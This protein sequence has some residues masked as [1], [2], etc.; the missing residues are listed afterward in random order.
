MRRIIALLFFCVTLTAIA[1]AP[2]Q[3]RIRISSWYWLNAAPQSDWA[4]DFVT[5][6]HLGFTDVLL[7]WGLDAAGVVTRKNDTLEAIR[8]AHRAGLGSYLFIWQPRAQSLPLNPKFQQVDSDGRLLETFDTFNPEW[9]HTQWKTYLQDI[10][11][12]YSREPGLAGYVFDD[13]FTSP[14]GNGFVS[15]GEFERKAFG[16]TLPKKP[17]EPDWDEW[18]QKRMGWWEDWAR[19][20]VG[21]LHDF[22]RHRDHEIYLE[23]TATSLLSGTRREHAGLDFMR[24]ARHFDAVGGYT[25]PRWSSDLDADKKVA[26][27]TENAIVGMK[28]MIPIDKQLIYT[29]WSANVAEERTPGAAQFPT[30]KQIREVCEIA[31]KLGIH[32]IDMYGYRIG[33]TQQKREEWTIWMPAEPAPYRLTGQFTQ[34]FIWDRPEIHDEL[35]TYLRSL[36]R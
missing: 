32:H 34:K 7:C 10:S 22:D 14:G 3:P 35:G 16:K 36:N 6:K 17:G 18:T 8:E 5:M 31:L 23:D 11:H 19:D 33:A 29:F 26:E 15:Y 12:T 27:L 20:T 4:G 21:Y 1:E 28:K 9:R 13:S 24:V 2:R 30:A 25:A